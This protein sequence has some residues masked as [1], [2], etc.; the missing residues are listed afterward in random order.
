M[1]N[2]GDVPKW[3]TRTLPVLQIIVVTVIFL[4]CAAIDLLRK[5]IFKVF[6]IDKGI[7]KISNCLEKVIGNYED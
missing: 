3:N 2:G 7:V 5:V 4:V 1:A 6:G